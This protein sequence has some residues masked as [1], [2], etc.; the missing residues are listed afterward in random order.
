MAKNNDCPISDSSLC[1]WI[2][3]SCDN[4]YVSTLKKSDQ[5]ISAMEDFEVTLSLLPSDFDKLQGEECQFCIGEK[6][7]RAGYA[8]ID[9]AHSEPK[10]ETGMFFGLGKKVRRR[11]GSYVLASISICRS[12]RT[13]MFIAGMLK[14]LL[15]IVVFAIAA[16]VVSIPSITAAL[17]EFGVLFVLA[18]SVALGYFIGSVISNAY[19]KAKKD[20]VRFDVFQ[21]P[22]CARMKERGWFLMQDNPKFI[23]SKKS[24]TGMIGKIKKDDGDKEEAVQTTLF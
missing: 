24:Q 19:I 10:S 5:A 1:Q 12:C 17:N 9:F 18:A 13:S 16:A 20:K 6:K 14:W 23:F 4:C 11:V 15:C 7:K 8:N 21:I 2:N 3:R 22:V